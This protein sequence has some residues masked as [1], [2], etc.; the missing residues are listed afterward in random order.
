M[1]H[2]VVRE[3]GELEL[4]RRNA[5]LLPIYSFLLGLIA[6]LGYIGLL[7]WMGGSSSSKISF[8]CFGGRQKMLPLNLLT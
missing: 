1:I 4:R 6:L 2:E 5:A 3:E 7:F 8:F